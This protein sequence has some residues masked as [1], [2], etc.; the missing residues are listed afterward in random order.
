MSSRTV[1]PE[2]LSVGQV[3]HDLV[4]GTIRLGGAA[5]YSAQTAAR[6]GKRTAVLTSYGKDY[7][8]DEVFNGIA[9]EVVPASDTSTFRNLYEKEG[10]VQFLYNQAGLL[11]T[12]NLP[13]AW[14]MT[15]VIYLC[16][17]LHEVSMETGWGDEGSMIGVAP[18]GW[19]RKWDADGRIE[20]RKWTGFE[21]LL[22]RANLLIVSEKDIEGIEELLHDFRSC[23]SMVIVTHAEKG[24]V[25]YTRGR[26]IAVGAYPAKERDPTG[27]GDCFGAAFLIRYRETG[28]LMEAAR[29]AS[30]VGSFVV[31]QDGIKGIPTREQVFQRM[32]THTLS[33]KEA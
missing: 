23:T 13:P 33:I 21:R 19:L 31:E 26:T 32:D 2:F 14:R 4:N 24:A 17:V 15:E 25:V 18:Q 1:I 30:C 8:G 7:V 16:P 20:A 9:R 11:E 22:Q 29:F 3:T 6:L 12:R 27:A 28:D 10:R 5:L